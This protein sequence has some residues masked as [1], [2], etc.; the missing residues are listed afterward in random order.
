VLSATELPELCAYLARQ[1]FPV[2]ADQIVNIAKILNAR[3]VVWGE[4]TAGTLAAVLRPILCKSE[5]DYPRLE[6]ILA[7]W[8]LATAGGPPSAVPQPEKRRPQKWR[9]AMLSVLASAMVIILAVSALVLWNEPRQFSVIVRAA[10]SAPAWRNSAPVPLA[11]AHVESPSCRGVSDA[12]GAVPCVAAPSQFPLTLEASHED[13]EARSVRAFE[14]L[15]FWQRLNA[16]ARLAAVS[17]TLASGPPATWEVSSVTIYEGQTLPPPFAISSTAP[18]P[19]PVADRSIIARHYHRVLIGTLA[20]LVLWL[21]W[22]RWIHHAPLVLRRQFQSSVD[23]QAR[24]ALA[25]PTSALLL[26]TKAFRLGLAWRQSARSAMTRMDIGATVRASARRAGW[27][28]PMHTR[29]RETR[30]IALVHTLGLADQYGQL[31]R[32]LAAELARSGADIHTYLFSGSGSAMQSATEVRHARAGPMVV[33]QAE[34]VLAEAGDATFLFFCEPCAVFDSLNGELLPWARTLFSEAHCVLLVLDA[35][36]CATPIA[37]RVRH[38]GALVLSFASCTVADLLATA[39]PAGGWSEP[40]APV[41]ANAKVQPFF[42]DGQLFSG[43]ADTRQIDALCSSLKVVLGARGF[44]WLQT[45][46]IFPELRWS[47]TLAVGEYLVAEPRLREKTLIRLSALPWLRAG[48]L[49][50]WLRLALIERLSREQEEKARHF[51]WTLF[52]KAWSGHGVQV[53]AHQPPW[54]KARRAMRAAQLLLRGASSGLA[55]ERLYARFLLGLNPVGLDLGLPDWT[56]KHMRN[57]LHAPQMALGAFAVASVF[58]VTIVLVPPDVVATASAPSP[59]PSLEP[60][61]IGSAADA[62]GMLVAAMIVPGSAVLSLRYADSNRPKDGWRALEFDLSTTDLGQ[63]L[64]YRL[65]LAPD[66]RT[67]IVLDG[68]TAVMFDL[69]GHKQPPLPVHSETAQVAAYSGNFNTATFGE[70][71]RS[72]N[73]PS[74]SAITTDPAD[75]HKLFSALP[76][77]LQVG[78]DIPE[79]VREF[80]SLGVPRELHLLQAERTSIFLA[81]SP[82]VVQAEGTSELRATAHVEETP[83]PAGRG[84]LV[85]QAL[86]DLGPA[87]NVRFAECFDTGEVRVWSRESRSR[88]LKL[89]EQLEPNGRDRCTAM[90][91]ARGQ[92]FLLLGGAEGKVHLVHLTASPVARKLDFGYSGRAAVVD[93]RFSPDSKLL[94]VA[95]ADGSFSLAKV[96]LIETKPVTIAS[97]SGKQAV[98]SVRTSDPPAGNSIVSGVP[99]DRFGL[100]KLSSVPFDDENSGTA[101]AQILLPAQPIPLR[102]RLTATATAHVSDNGWM[103]VRIFVNDEAT[104]CQVARVY[105]NPKSENV[106]SATATCNVELLTNA[107]HTFRLEAP[108]F[109]ADALSAK[110]GAQYRR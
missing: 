5:T 102:A 99:N 108:N 79:R 25:A 74:F 104:P 23:R 69:N 96:V 92:Q 70:F 71:Q 103:E 35:S 19:P 8:R 20:V 84:Q 98:K 60:Q 52:I 58:A 107:P 21:L 34:D 73:R 27:F 75:F 53:A 105:K 93:L 90:V 45:C 50:D 37:A 30:L 18:P 16:P 109:N 40:S 94:T 46:A 67:V 3:E 68:K 65:K 2:T 55:E 82:V 22:R 56:K 101:T 42:S 28:T 83:A 89:V 26:Q 78:S 62:A 64:P 81:G 10:P 36:T 32:L 44:R 100:S 7:T 1:G 72:G 49:P 110:L 6:K 43:P 39:K 86:S 38:A 47:V 59:Q 13:F 29:R 33:R 95:R 14:G 9:W 24:L 54:R 106:L 4:L 97:P 66:A 17:I 12:Y 87:L 91:F 80:H 41:N 51:Y 11:G 31:N 76:R 57:A 15:T 63:G 88:A 61:A 85:T 48:Y 77:W